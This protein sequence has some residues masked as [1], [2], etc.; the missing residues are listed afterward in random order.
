MQL[1]WY[2]SLV[3]WEPLHF[4]AKFQRTGWIII[5]Y[6]SQSSLLYFFKFF[7]VFFSTKMPC[8]GAKIQIT[9]KSMKN[10]KFIELCKI[11]T[12]SFKNIQLLGNFQKHNGLFNT[13]VTVFSTVVCFEVVVCDLSN[14]LFCF[15]ALHYFILTFCIHTYLVVYLC[16]CVWV[17][18]VLIVWIIFSLFKHYA[19]SCIA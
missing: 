8:Q 1:S 11:C 7:G 4:Q 3:G 6:K 2:V 13:V 9:N 16:M 15:L 19:I 14:I 18:T 5:I 10:G 17:C 12:K